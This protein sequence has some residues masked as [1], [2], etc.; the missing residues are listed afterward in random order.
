LIARFQHYFPGWFY[1]R[2]RW[3]TLDGVIPFKLFY[4][5]LAVINNLE[6]G[7]ELVISNGVGLGYANARN[8]KNAKIKAQVRKLSRRAFPEIV[9]YEDG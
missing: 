9:E 2:T 5:L 7:D 4:N 8:G 6:A 1:D 3:P